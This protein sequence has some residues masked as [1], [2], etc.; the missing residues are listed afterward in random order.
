MELPRRRATPHLEYAVRIA[1]GHMHTQDGVASTGAGTVK[2][3]TDSVACLP[4]DLARDYDIDLIPVRIS[5]AGRTYSDNE[6]DLP[7]ALVDAYRVTDIDTT[8]WPPE[9]YARIYS[10]TGPR[11]AS[12]VHVVAFS[13]FTSTM[14]LAQEGAILARK[15]HPEL[16]IEIVDSGATGMAQGFVALA[17]A[18]AAQAG[19]TIEECCQAAR[20]MA[21][22]LISIFALESLDHVARTGRVTRLAAWASSLLRVTPVVKLSQGREQPLF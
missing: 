17:A 6:E 21:D 1:H 19:A 18:R 3:V 13:R 5:V 7:P 20:E 4:D 9:H 16:E 12:I 22:R 14:S 15:Q 10:D 2:V 11:H 8:P